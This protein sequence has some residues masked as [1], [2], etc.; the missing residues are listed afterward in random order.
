[1]QTTVT[2]PHHDYPSSVRANLE[3][4]LSGLT[5][6]FDRIV[7]LR[8]ILAKESE[9]HRVELVANVG[10][11]VTLV[12]DSRR[13]M[14][15]TAIDDALHRMRHVLSKHKQKLVDRQRRGGRPGH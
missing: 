6:Y 5:R 12:V 15:T 14:L 2:M 8:A 3:E 10:H 7:W 13:E 1:M 11:G 4:K 9:N